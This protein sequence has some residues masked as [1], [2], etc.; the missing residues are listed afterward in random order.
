[1]SLT[2]LLNMLQ[3][4]LQ[5][6]MATLGQFYLMALILSPVL[7]NIAFLNP[8]SAAIAKFFCVKTACMETMTLCIGAALQLCLWSP[9]CHP[10]SLLSFCQSDHM[11]EAHRVRFRCLHTFHG[12]YLRSRKTFREAILETSRLCLFFIF[13]CYGLHIFHSHTKGPI[14]GRSNDEDARTWNGLFRINV[15]EFPAD[16][17]YS[18]GCSEVLAGHHCI[19]RLHA[20]IQTWHG[21]NSSECST[22]SSCRHNRGLHLGHPCC[23][24]LLSCW[25]SLL[26]H[27]TCIS[28]VRYKYP[29]SHS[30][31]FP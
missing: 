1:M 31:F 4:A 12:F 29:E 15:D 13:S 23:S 10:L 24:R 16:V 20:G 19:P 27:S 7:T 26:A 11:V 9:Q 2:S 14:D 3:G 5:Q 30:H 6:Q 25:A 17:I 18:E 21:L 28:V 8:L 22:S